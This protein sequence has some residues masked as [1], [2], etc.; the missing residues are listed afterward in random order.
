MNLFQCSIHRQKG[1]G[2][3]GDWEPS[4]CSYSAIHWCPAEPTILSLKKDAAVT[5]Y[6]QREN[7]HVK[8]QMKK[9][10][11]YSLQADTVTSMFI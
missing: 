5:D 9:K 4:E 1:W 6:H 11:I 7:P 10:G 2:G 8:E 3:Q